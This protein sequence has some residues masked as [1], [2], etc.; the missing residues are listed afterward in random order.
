M[1]DSI[2]P[3]E[4]HKNASKRLCEASIS[5]EYLTLEWTDDGLTLSENITRRLIFH[6]ANSHIHFYDKEVQILFGFPGIAVEKN[7]SNVTFKRRTSNLEIRLKCLLEDRCLVASY[8]I[9]NVGSDPIRLADLQILSF[10]RRSGALSHLLTNDC[11]VF[12]LGASTGETEQVWSK[13]PG[14]K[15]VFALRL[16]QKEPDY[17]SDNLIAAQPVNAGGLTPHVTF[18]F[19]RIAEV[20][21]GFSINLAS[22]LSAARF[23]FRGTTLPAGCTRQLPRLYIDGLSPV[24]EALEAAADRVAAIYRPQVTKS[25]PSGWCS[26][27]YYYVHVAEADILENLDFIR[28]NQDRFPYHYIQI[29]DGYQQHWGD[30]LLPSRK[31][32]HDMAWLAQHIKSA[33]FKPGI[34]V[35]PLI[36]T[37]PSHLFQQHPDWALRDFKTGSPQTL[38]GWS[39]PDEN[40][41]VILDGTNPRFLEHLRKIFHTM[42]HEWGYDYF[43]LDAT[44][45]GAYSGLRYDPTKTGIE[46]VRMALQAIREAI[47]PEKYILGC[48][49]PFGAAIGLVNG[50]RVSDDI[51]TAFRAEQ[52]TCPIEVSMPQTIHRSFIHGKWWHNDPDCVLV[53]SSGTPHESSLSHSGLTMDEARFFMTVVGLTQG[54]QMVGEKMHALEEERLQLLDTI[55]PPVNAPAIPLDFFA[56]QPS[57]LLLPTRHGIILGLLNWQHAECTKTVHWF[58]LGLVPDVPQQVY[59]LWTQSCIG[60]HRHSMLN[61]DVP[62]HGSRVLLFRPS[63]PH[64]SFLG[65]DGHISC[66]ATLL[67]CENWSHSAK[68]LSLKITANRSGTI[69]FH[70]P[71]EW[72]PYRSNLILESEN[73]W[74]LSINKGEQSIVLQFYKQ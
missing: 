17:I 28:L 27:Y 23:A 55:Q 3:P 50:E 35:A 20:P 41:W 32:P 42:A 18:S 6:R 49:V 2:R 19:D 7:V 29:D 40:P 13:V 31:F 34:W 1:T 37:V 9:T 72:H 44:A 58:E 56:S 12:S 45:F 47:G 52:F 65:F 53:R 39:P 15:R 62:A 11:D 14:N 69:K 70:V 48:G 21:S 57:R 5:N 51:S 63:T 46:A 36:A 59:E 68:V 38:Q 16:N 43:K 10:D 74:N 33:G 54:I 4:I 25:V 64:P 71:Q 26:W 30:W 73:C 24:Q 61:V 66:G 8:Q 60:G 67:D 22:G